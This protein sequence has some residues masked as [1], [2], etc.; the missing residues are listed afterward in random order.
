MLILTKYLSYKDECM[1]QLEGLNKI[2]L[3]P[4]NA[5]S[6]NHMYMY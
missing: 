1:Y 6:M 3:Q 2:R 5:L 4:Y